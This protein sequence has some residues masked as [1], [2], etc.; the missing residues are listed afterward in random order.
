MKKCILLAMLVLAKTFVYAQCTPG[1]P[2]LSCTESPNYP[3][4]CPDTLAVATVGTFYEGDIT[5][6][7]PTSFF[8]PS[9][10]L[11]VTMNT[12]EIN[13]VAGLPFG[14]QWSANPQTVTPSQ[15]EFTAIRVCGTPL[16][17]GVYPLTISITVQASALGISQTIN[18][19]IPVTLFVNPS[20]GGNDAFSILNPS[21]C[22]P[23]QTTFTTNYPSNGNAGYTYNWDFGNGFNTQLENPPVVDYTTL[24]NDTFF[25]VTHTI[26]I[27]T[28]GYVLTNVQVTNIGC[29]DNPGNNPDVYI[30]IKNG[31]G[32]EVLNNIGGQIEGNPPFNFAINNL[33]LNNGPYTIQVWDDDSGL[34]GADDNCFNNQEGSNASLNLALPANGEAGI[35]TLI[36]QGGSIILNYTVNK[37]VL[38]I[39]ASDTVFV[40]PVPP[41]P[42][43]TGPSNGEFCDGTSAT[44][45][46]TWGFQYQWFKND[47]ILVDKTTQ[48]IQVDE[49]GNYV[50]Q[51]TNQFG[52]TAVSDT[53]NLTM[54]P[55]P[56]VPSI[57]L[58]NQNWPQT[59]LTGFGLQWFYEGFIVDGQTSQ[60]C[61]PVF[62]GNY[63][64]RAENEF[65]CY[66]Y[67]DTIEV[68]KL[69]INPLTWAS[70]LTIYPNP[71]ESGNNLIING[72]P[73]GNYTFTLSDLTGKELLIS[74]YYSLNYGE[75]NINTL[76]LAKGTYLLKIAIDNYT[77][78]KRVVVN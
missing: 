76:S 14:M 18:Q 12:V 8:E 27:D 48:S 55:T 3:R 23:L 30:I 39:T 13:G 47:T 9:V 38:E 49:P 24:T 25:V 35:S 20:Q 52:C 71:L 44:L 43:A 54:L 66:S 67:S 62:N 11:T 51:V 56:P 17:A 33:P 78:N 29:T 53:V 42:T 22:A 61:T 58:N 70:N 28:I 46:S 75:I 1:T 72:L 6:W 73:D 4:T 59:S 64:V 69:S 7:F 74:N 65:G 19:N 36:A 60:I 45:S 21:G 50:V 15:N 41:T 63:Y 10:S 34:L 40:N 37:P 77:V 68:T 16:N 26:T 2:D 5:M 32:Q 31:Q 57:N